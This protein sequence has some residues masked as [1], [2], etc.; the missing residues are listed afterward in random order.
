MADQDQAVQLVSRADLKG[1]L[2]AAV[3]ELAFTAGQLAT[4][5]PEHAERLMATAER[6]HGLLHPA[7]A[8]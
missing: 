2:E 1:G 3:G 5:E 8:E 4:S 7:A 6:L